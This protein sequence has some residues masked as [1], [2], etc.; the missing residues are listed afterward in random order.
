MGNVPDTYHVVFQG[1]HGF[2]HEF[3]SNYDDEATARAD[4]DAL[5]GVPTIT[6]VEV[7]RYVWPDNKPIQ[8]YSRV[9]TPATNV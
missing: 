5:L 8:V 1:Q 4:A 9:L 6:G 7:N 3:G 2:W